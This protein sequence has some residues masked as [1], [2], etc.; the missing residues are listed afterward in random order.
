[1][2]WQLRNYWGRLVRIVLP[3]RELFGHFTRFLPS[4]LGHNFVSDI[5]EGEGEGGDVTF[6]LRRDG[7]S[8]VL[9][10]EQETLAT[11]SKWTVLAERFEWALQNELGSRAPH[12]VFVHSGVVALGDRALLLPACSYSGKSTMTRALTKLGAT[13]FSDEFA[14]ID[15]DGWVYPY[16]RAMTLRRESGGPDRRVLPANPTLSAD[17][18]RISLVVDCQYEKGARWAPQPLSQ[19]EGLLSLFSN[20]VSAQLSPERD[21][22]WLTA[23]MKDARA[24]RTLRGDV[25]HSAPK[26]LAMLEALL[27]PPPP[28]QRI[29]PQ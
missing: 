13:Y 19:G 18:C 12:G 15:R 21:I 8:L 29:D 24:Y 17:R 26:L 9:Y 5:N 20:T 28:T 14:V 4:S 16:R 27:K 2:V 25:R 11:H 3:D 10:M 23:A 6:T 1:M 7:N 22:T